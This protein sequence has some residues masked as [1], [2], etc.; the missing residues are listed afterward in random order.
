MPNEIQVQ[1]ICYLEI[2]DFL[3]LRLASKSL[4]EILQL[5]A[6]ILSRVMLRKSPLGDDPI[7]L[8]QLCRPVQPLQNLN[9]VLHMLHR[10]TIVSKMARAI[11][12]YVQVKF[13]RIKSAAGRKNFAPSRALL[14][15]RMRLP[16]FIIYRFLEDLRP[17][18]QRSLKANGTSSI[19]DRLAERFSSDDEMQVDII[20]RIPQEMLLP[21]FQFYGLM[22]SA[23]NHKLHPPTYAGTF[24]RKLRGWDR[25]PPS[26]TQI[27]SVLLYGGMDEVLAV[28]VQPTYDARLDALNAALE[29]VENPTAVVIPNRVEGMQILPITDGSQNPPVYYI[30]SLC[31]TG[32]GTALRHLYLSWT[33]VIF[34]RKLAEGDAIAYADRHVNIANPFSYIIDMLK[35]YGVRPDFERS[36]V[37]LRDLENRDN[38]PSDEEEPT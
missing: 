10:D 11:A 25:P 27:A 14:E 9:Y 16:V 24:E 15:E 38:A 33:W 30:S 3:S 8:E 12:D 13:Y 23:L 18:L 6:S 37:S 26:D 4:A 5:N 28:M 20:G 35:D 17:C 36:A 29:R 19:E 7:Y 22:A 21:A 32:G 1:I 34:A 2:S 31:S